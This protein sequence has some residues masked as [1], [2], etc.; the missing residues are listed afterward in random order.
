MTRYDNAGELLAD[1]NTVTNEASDYVQKLIDDIGRTERSGLTVPQKENVVVRLTAL[2]A[3]LKAVAANAA[4]PIPEV[5]EAHV[6]MPG[7]FKS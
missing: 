4:S 2:A 3:F 7:P 6:E 1:F 5:P